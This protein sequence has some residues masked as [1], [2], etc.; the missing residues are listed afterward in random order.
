MRDRALKLS[1]ELGGPLMALDASTSQA[2]VALVNGSRNRVVEI[3]PDASAL[4][5]ESLAEAVAGLVGDEGLVV[6]ELRGI[7]VGLGPGSFTGLRVALALVKGIA[8]G[9]SVP[10]FGVSSLALMASRGAGR[11]VSVE[12]D[13]Q[14]RELFTAVYDVGDDG[15]PVVVLEDRATVRSEW[16]EE[17]AALEAQ[18]DEVLGDVDDAGRAVPRALAGIALAA[19]ELRAGRTQ[20]LD[21]LVPC[22]LKVSE[23]ERNL[24]QNSSV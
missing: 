2:S 23:A 24:G 1:A 14:R 19:E 3:E 17:L 20:P 10:V 13:A 7:V 22:Y 5:S 15:V 4:P 21:E 6:S 9:A 18:P 12:I 11:R 16:R 8:F